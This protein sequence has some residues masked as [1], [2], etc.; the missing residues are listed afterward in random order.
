MLLHIHW[1]HN[2][3]AISGSLVITYYFMYSKRSLNNPAETFG[4]VKT[5][6]QTISGLDITNSPQYCHRVDE[7]PITSDGGSVTTL[8]R[9][10]IEVDGLISL[11]YNVDVTPS[12]TGGTADPFIFTLD[13]HYQSTGI[14]TKNNAPDY[15]I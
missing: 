14:G 7:I 5:V 12:I 13:I 1:G 9:N 10:L 4:D 15:Y 3:T 8:D 6:T 11:H 2:G